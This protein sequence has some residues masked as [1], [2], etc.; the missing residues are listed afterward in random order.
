MLYH[1]ERMFVPDE[2]HDCPCYVYAITDARTTH[3]TINGRR[4]I[5][6][7]D[8]R[9]AGNN[10]EE[11]GDRNEFWLGE[12]YFNVI[13]KHATS[14]EPDGGPWGPDDATKE[15]PR[16]GS[17]I[18]IVTIC[19]GTSGMKRSNKNELFIAYRYQ[20]EVLDEQQDSIGS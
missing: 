11:T 2:D 14:C 4:R 15:Q 8:W 3:M 7:D 19:K 13:L 18:P 9:F 17:T 16:H 20:I 12:T 5:R 6:E 1:E 10:D